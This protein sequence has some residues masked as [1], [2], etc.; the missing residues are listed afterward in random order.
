MPQAC[1]DEEEGEGVPASALPTRGRAA[2][3]RRGRPTTTST[4]ANNNSNKNNKPH[5]AKW[6]EQGWKFIREQSN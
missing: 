2:A 1:R 3:T 6:E 5:S 4:T